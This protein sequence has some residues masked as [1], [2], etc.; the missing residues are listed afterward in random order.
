MWN[1]SRQQPA[2]CWAQCLA[3]LPR[4]W[5]IFSGDSNW[6][7]VWERFVHLLSFVDGVKAVY[8]NTTTR[9]NPQTYP[10]T[11]D[12]RWF[13]RDAIFT[14]PDERVFRASLRF[15]WSA[16]T[17]LAIYAKESK[18]WQPIRQCGVPTRWLNDQKVQTMTQNQLRSA[19]GVFVDDTSGQKYTYS[20]S[21]PAYINSQPEAFHGQIWDAGPPHAIFWTHGL[22]HLPVG[23][24]S[25][26]SYGTGAAMA[27]E[28][29]QFPASRHEYFGQQVASWLKDIRVV[30]WATNSR[31]KVH[32]TLRNHDLA[33]DYACQLDVAERLSLPLF[34]VWKYIHNVG[35]DVI[36]FHFA[37]HVADKVLSDLMHEICPACPGS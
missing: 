1:R 21:G 31:I 35:Q 32:P 30:K 19:N 33:V 23:N 13:D 9:Q 6:R 4:P 18:W 22:W 29:G 5:I 11:M 34:D 16:E 15:M 3:S 8:A 20:C 10:E 24:M 7:G 25:C 37:R 12:E 14:L 28:F 17:M 26:E 36:D 27:P 2:N